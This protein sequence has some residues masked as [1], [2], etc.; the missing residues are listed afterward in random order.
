MK[1][2]IPLFSM[3]LILLLTTS[4]VSAD[5]NTYYVV[6]VGYFKNKA[7]ME[8]SVDIIAKQGLPVYKVAFNGGYR[9]FV[10]NYESREEAEKVAQI[11]NEM[12]FE[13]LVRT[14]EKKPKQISNTALHQNKVNETAAPKTSDK[15]LNKTNNKPA[16]DNTNSND[17]SV[18]KPDDTDEIASFNTTKTEEE[19]HTDKNDKK[20]DKAGST[21]NRELSIQKEDSSHISGELSKPV[22]QLS[23]DEKQYERSNTPN[24]NAL[25]HYMFY[26]TL[27][28][29]LLIGNIAA[30]RRNQ[31]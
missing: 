12:G 25:I 26:A 20:I 6:Q 31:E 7:L 14:M 21:D 19:V 1:K 11:V 16:T 2:Y 18:L 29:I 8:K 23:N 4:E 9:I 17:R 15:P 13:A 5:S 28:S 10:G 22:R 27:I 24:N 3:L 30:N